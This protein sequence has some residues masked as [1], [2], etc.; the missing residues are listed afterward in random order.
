[1]GYG[2]RQ[3]LGTVGDRDKGEIFV[4]PVGGATKPV[5]LFV[6]TDKATYALILKREDMPADTIV[7]RDRAQY[8]APSADARHLPGQAPAHYSVLKSMLLAMASDR[9]PSD[10]HME[11]VGRPVQL[12]AEARFTLM[13]VY[14]SRDLVG[15]KYLLTNVSGQPMVLAE[16]EFDRDEPHVEGIAIETHNLLPGES[17]NVFVIRSGAQE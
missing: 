12:W 16:Q 13:R 11:E 10:I 7:I 6:S 1:M 8:Q 3:F 17:T 15:E 14:E 4:K 2:L 5:N 9:L